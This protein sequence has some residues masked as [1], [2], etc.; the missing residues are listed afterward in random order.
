MDYG[1]LEFMRLTDE[2]EV[3][4]GEHLDVLHERRTIR[5][6]QQAAAGEAQRLASAGC[7]GAAMFKVAYKRP[8]FGGDPQTD[9]LVDYGGREDATPN[10]GQGKGNIAY[11]AMPIDDDQGE[12]IVCA[13]DDNVGLW[14]RFLGT[15]EEEE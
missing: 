14:P 3:Q 9:Q 12:V 5:I 2:I 4:G 15:W 8:V 10:D 1:G 13:E 11:L 7:G 6:P